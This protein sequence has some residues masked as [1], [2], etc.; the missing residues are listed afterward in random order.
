ML[1]VKE[2][3]W[4]LYIERR[5]LVR[6]RFSSPEKAWLREAIAF[7]GGGYTSEALTGQ[8]AHPMLLRVSG[9]SR[10]AWAVRVTVCVY[11]CHFLRRGKLTC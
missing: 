2:C 7:H 1:T 5:R 3:T 8:V 4:F 6:M 9:G 10:H 11:V